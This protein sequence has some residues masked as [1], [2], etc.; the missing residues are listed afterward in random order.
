M[1][2][3]LVYTGRRLV[4][5]WVW[6]VAGLRYAWRTEHSFRTWVWANLVS[7]LFALG[8]DLTAAE[9]AL[10]IAL[11]LLILAAELL[12]TAIEDAVDYVSAADH[13]LAKCAKD[14]GSAGVTVTAVAAGLAWLVVLWG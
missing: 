1:R 6:S 9:R 8:L 2:E 5:R 11:G 13:P 12:N 14:A 10:V 3:K 7:V 4:L